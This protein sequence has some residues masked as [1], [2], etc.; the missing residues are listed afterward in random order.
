M[1]AQTLR[2]YSIN[3]VVWRDSSKAEILGLVMSSGEQIEVPLACQLAGSDIR[4]IIAAGI[5][6]G[7]PVIDE[8]TSWAKSMEVCGAQG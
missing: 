7:S 1:L 8:L 3:E 6:A 5:W 4:A 2:G